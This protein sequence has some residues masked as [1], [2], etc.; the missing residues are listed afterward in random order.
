MNRRSFCLTSLL[1]LPALSSF[2]RSEPSLFSGHDP[3][4][5]TLHSPLDHPFY[6]WP[7][8]LLSYPLR[9]DHPIDATHL[10]LVNDATN[11][12]VPTQLSAV[13][14]TSATLH[15]LTDLPANTHRNFTLTLAN[16]PQTHPT[17][18]HATAEANSLILSTGKLRIRIPNTQLIHAATAPAPI[19]Q[20]S[21]DKI[22]IGTN[23]L[24][25][26]HDRLTTLTTKRLAAGP[27]FLTYQLTYT[28]ASGKHYTATIQ[29]IAGYDHVYL[30]ED[31]DAVTGSITTT[32]TSVHPTHRQSPNHPEPV[33]AAPKPYDNYPWERIDQ[34]LLNRDT[35]FGSPNTIYPDPL[36]A[37]ELPFTLGIYQASTESIILPAANFWDEKSNDALGIFIPKTAD[38]QDHEYAYEVAADTLQVHYFYRDNQLTFHWPL[39]RG[40]RTTALAFYDHAK[41]KQTQQALEQAARGVEHNG[42]TYRVQLD[43]SSYTT[44]LQ[45]LYGPLDL[46][47]FKDWQ[48]TYP[49]TAKRPPI[50]FPAGTTDNPE[51][52]LARVLT[53]RYLCTLPITGTREDDGFSATKARQ[54]LDP[55]VCDYN[56]LE[57]LMTP[58]QRARLTAAFLLIAYIH[59]GDEYLP[60]TPMLGGH[61]NYMSDVKGAPPAMSF[62]FPDHPL[63]EAWLDMWEKWVVLCTRYNTRPAVTTWNADSGRWTENLG[64]YVWAFLR[65]AMRAN[66]IAMQHDGVQRFVTPQLAEL[67]DWL[68]N[69]LSAPFNGETEEAWKTLR[70]LD[71]GHEWGAV[72]PGKGPRR[73]HL[74]IGAHSERRM[75]PRTLWAFGTNLQRYAPLAAEHAMWA[76]LPT[77]QDME[78]PPGYP[79]PWKNLMY[80]GADNRGTNPHLRSLK[81]TGY[82]IVL[83]SAVDTP[84]EVS[85]HLQ[86]IDEGPNYRWGWPAEGSCGVLYFFAAG[87]SYSFNGSEDAG[88]RRNQDTDYCT[89]FGV[90]K[91]GEFR[92][93]GKNVLSSP[94]YPLATG[95]FA[96]LT[97]RPGP[98]TYSAP[99]YLSRSVLLAGHDYFLLFDHVAHHSLQH[100]LSW[101]TRRGSELPT[102]TLLRGG[103]GDGRHTHATKIEGDATT[104]LW[105]DGMGDSLA[106]VSHRKV[107]KIQSTRYGCT[108]K[109]EHI[110]D[111][112][113]L[114]PTPIHF[115]EGPL[116]FAGTAGLIR[117]TE[118]G[119]D[120]ALFHGTSITADGLTVTTTDTDLGISGSI[121][122]G[123]SPRGDFF[124]PHA[125]TVTI[126]FP[127]TSPAPRFCIDGAPQSAIQGTLHLPAGHHHWELTASAPI[128]IAPQ[129]LRTENRSNGARVILTPV[130]S[131]THYRLE[132]SRDNGATWSAHSTNTEPTL[133][134]T[135]LTNGEKVHLRAI[136]LNDQD[137][138]APSDDYP[139]YVTAD[140]PPPP[141]GLRLT[142]TEG[143]ATL[144]WGELLGVS[145][146]RL[147]ART[148]GINGFVLLHEGLDRTYTHHD[149]RI[150]PCAEK[151]APLTPYLGE[152]IEYTVAAVNLNGESPRSRIADTNPNTWRNWD[153][154]PNEPFRR[155]YSFAPDTPPDPTKWPRYYPS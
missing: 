60:L 149:T 137:E 98:T 31:M 52:L 85:V 22:W 14:P 144:T 113:F 123:R 15:F 71:Y 12:P 79:P 78:T 44:W 151:P 152:V 38:W 58:E 124:A 24:T 36:P 40:R 32:W 70:Q 68:V 128:P 142:L 87:E 118:Q 47:A 76:A 83:R 1:S 93:I 100:R 30:T 53:S 131:A 146:Y 8:T 102:I 129:I 107:L 109:S 117:R 73:V 95:Q 143:S 48:L 74:P 111:H 7:T 57:H 67:A 88:D 29:A 121:A 69:A 120:F 6:A 62:L 2:L 139:L 26:D 80:T 103:D 92:A 33:F 141:D 43:Y 126:T 34:P 136:A 75:P 3:L 115:E 54:I 89:N 28:T 86:Q 148:R 25:L 42:L 150:H 51:E 66:Y 96:E 9:F 155:V 101:F 59:A 63:A 134:A 50:I 21:R 127:T 23:T 99:E 106:V 39:A 56:R 154:R 55:W 94:M 116:A 97:S 20:L 64:T 4:H 110:D 46:N 140:P 90:F 130:A 112:V 125:S 16:T 41:D 147:Y 10:R 18:I 81:H 108:V 91:D 114:N 138:S 37:N 35:R 135:T 27:L 17:Q 19:Q 61:P 49:E 132:L 72:A 119:Y 77:D 105:F 133:E 84:N 104:G 82:G 45:N 11:E 122:K 65:P 5:F 145:A 153:P 13:T